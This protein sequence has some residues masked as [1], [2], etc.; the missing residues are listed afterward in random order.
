MLIDTRPATIL[1]C[2]PQHT[3]TPEQSPLTTILF[4]TADDTTVV[5]AASAHPKSHVLGLPQE[6]VC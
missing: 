1:T 6:L 4:V 2:V 5:V 3:E